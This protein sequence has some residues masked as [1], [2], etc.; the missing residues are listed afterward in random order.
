[1]IDLII[2]AAGDGKR[3][4]AITVPKV[5]YPV[6]GQPNLDR[7]IQHAKSSGVFNKINVIIK[8]TAQ[9]QFEQHISENNLE[10]I[11]LV[12]IDSGLGDGHALMSGLFQIEYNCSNKQI[13]IWG[14]AYLES[15]DIFKELSNIDS[16]DAAIM[17]PVVYENNPYVTILTNERFEII[18]ADFS[19]LGE[20]HNSGLHDQS[21]FLI[22]KN[23]VADCLHNMHCAIWKNGR[24]IT[25]SKELNFLHLFHYLYNINEPAKCYITE[26]PT[27]SFNSIEEVINIEKG[28]YGI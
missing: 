27:K 17:V 24:Y 2:V 13:V 12:P 21:V 5:L 26:Y 19:K 11:H 14:D 15:D 22:S 6:N 23:I 28:E 10:N 18:S 1:M 16:E 20:T 9:K 7:I 3:M 4:G 8:K 25:E